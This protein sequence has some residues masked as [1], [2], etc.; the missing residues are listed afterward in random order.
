MTS[1][2]EQVKL[3][4]FF[5]VICGLLDNKAPVVKNQDYDTARRICRI[6][7]GSL[8]KPVLL[9]QNHGDTKG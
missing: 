1:A 3:C 9:K 7:K 2:E 4:N 5:I 6:E 8:S